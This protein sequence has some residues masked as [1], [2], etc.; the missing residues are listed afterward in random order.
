M[1][2][3]ALVFSL[4]L[5]GCGGFGADHSPTGDPAALPTDKPEASPASPNQPPPADTTT[6]VTPN[7]PA[8]REDPRVVP[9]VSTAVPETCETLA[10]KPPQGTFT[11]SSPADKDIVEANAT[12]N[13]TVGE[14]GTHQYEIAIAIST[15]PN[16]GAYSSINAMRPKTT[17]HTMSGRVV[18]KDAIAAPWTGT[19]LGGDVLSEWA[20][21]A[22]D[23]SFN[24][25]GTV[26]NDTETVI[27]IAKKTDTLVEGTWLLRGTGGGAT[28]SQGTFKAPIVKPVP[29]NVDAP[30][31]CCR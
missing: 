12:L 14:D 23:S 15:E 10:R 20:E 2:R 11:S 6:G 7:P 9:P 19:F 31:R 29:V 25:G 4:A 13:D 22:D 27:T 28:F 1:M 5:V 26:S 24:G 17:R 16:F 30:F 21:C 18:S 8:P 3:M